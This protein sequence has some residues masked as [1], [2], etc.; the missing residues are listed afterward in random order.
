MPLELYYTSG[1]PAKGNR[2]NEK[3][4]NT[5]QM[6]A[7]ASAKTEADPEVRQAL[8]RL[9]TGAVPGNRTIH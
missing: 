9:M 4:Y 1:I 5:N 2:M 3:D 8:L 7:L 6:D